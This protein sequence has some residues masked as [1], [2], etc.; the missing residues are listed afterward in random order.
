QDHVYGDIGIRG[1][2][3][4]QESVQTL[5]LQSPTT[6]DSG[7]YHCKVEGVDI[8]STLCTVTIEVLEPCSQAYVHLSSNISNV[9]LHEGELFQWKVEIKTFPSNPLMILRDP[10]GL[11]LERKIKDECES[12]ELYEKNNVTTADFGRYVLQVQTKTINQTCNSSILGNTSVTLLVLSPPHIN[13]VDGTVEMEENR[14]SVMMH[15]TCVVVAYPPPSITWTFKPL[16]SK[17]KPVVVGHQDY[18][19]PTLRLKMP[20]RTTIEE[21]SLLGQLLPSA[22]GNV[23]ASTISF[24]TNNSGYLRCLV[25]NEYGQHQS[26]VLLP[27]TASEN[28]TLRFANASVSEQ[29]SEMIADLDSQVTINCSVDG[30]PAPTIKWYKDGTL[31][32]TTKLRD[33]GNSTSE[34]TLLDQI[35]AQGIKESQEEFAIKSK[36]VMKLLFPSIKDHHEGIYMCVANNGREEIQGT[37]TIQVKV[38]DPFLTLGDKV[39]ISVCVLGFLVLVYTMTRIHRKIKKQKTFHMSQV[40]FFHESCDEL[41]VHDARSRF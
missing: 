38:P 4:D 39:G 30:T 24:P 12:W 20:R 17:G 22:P 7:S 13:S 16:Y 9:T 34:Q 29:G 15:G 8:I 37:V 1:N 18:Q 41:Y 27:L 33:S 40:S 31:I 21:G 26:E 28:D 6:N 10:S 11:V 32:N 19:G 23:W 2:G 25:T 5:T 36:E 3:S 14:T 35:I